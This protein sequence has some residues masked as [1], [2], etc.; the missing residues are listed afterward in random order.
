MR[1][2]FISTE[3]GGIGSYGG[4]GA[5]T[6]DVAGGLAARGVDTY[7]VIPNQPN[8]RPV[9]TIDGITV[10]SCPMGYYRDLKNSRPFA[11]VFRMIDAD[12]YH[13]QEPNI[14]TC[15]AQIGQPEKKHVVTFQDPRT[16][17]DWRKQWASH[18]PS[19]WWEFRFQLAYQH[20]VGRAV[21]SADARYC[22]AKYI[23][24]KAANLYRLSSRPG[25]LPNPV[26]VPDSC[27]PKASEPTVCFVGRWDAIKRPELFVQLASRFPTVKF[28]LIGKDIHDGAH[29]ASIR[30]RCAQLGNIDTPGWLMPAER[31]RLLER[32]W[33]LVNTSTKECLPVSYLE[34]CAQRCA[35]LSH[36]NADDFA[37][38]FGYWAEEG[39]LEDY[40]RG[41]EF[42]L[43]NNRW[44]ERGEKGYEYVKNTHEF[45]R[46]ID[47]HLRVYEEVLAR[48]DVSLN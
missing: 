20:K 48:R 9:Q 25:F 24:N 21:R 1:V 27:G 43:E 3:M 6:R 41:L 33:I 10:L 14:G 8:Q 31:N 45:S 46:V 42:L 4:F 47:Q 17:E 26:D 28:I 38:E 35:I 39:D 12:V 29:D 19:R 16:I 34:A 36:G 32:S 13:T 5:V 2:C 30:Q 40:H 44:K 15:L 7:V 11:A 18:R 22:Q 37:G 23:I